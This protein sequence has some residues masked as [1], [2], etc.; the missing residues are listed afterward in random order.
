[1]KAS[2]SENDSMRIVMP[3][4]EF[5]YEDVDCDREYEFLGGKCRL[6]RFDADREIPAIP[7]VS[8]LD[9]AYMKQESWALLV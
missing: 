1:M 4:F 7:G 5:V 3:L 9:R 8:E 2:A 6:I